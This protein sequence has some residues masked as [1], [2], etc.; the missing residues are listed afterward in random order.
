MAENRDEICGSYDGVVEKTVFDERINLIERLKHNPK[1]LLSE[2]NIV[3]LAPADASD[4]G[5]PAASVDHHI[6][7]TVFEHIP[8]EDIARIL[9]EAKRILK[10]YRLHRDI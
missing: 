3:Y 6:S 1:K 10:E 2:A 7:I 4:T 9:T 8:K 5:L